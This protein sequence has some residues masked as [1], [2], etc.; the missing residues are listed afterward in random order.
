LEGEGAI[1]CWCGIYV[2]SC[3]L[4]EQ[5]QGAEAIWEVVDMEDVSSN[6]EIIITLFEFDEESCLNTVIS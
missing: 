3:E 6:S 1:T 5:Q 2:P 4:S